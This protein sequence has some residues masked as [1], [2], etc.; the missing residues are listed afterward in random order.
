MNHISVLKDEAISYLNVKPEG[1]YVDCTLGGG[2][3]AEALLTRLKTGKLI[4]FDQDAYAVARAKE[5]LRDHA[6]KLVV[7]EANFTHLKITL[8]RLS[9]D[10]VDGVLYDLGVS[11]FHFDDPSRGFSYN[12]DAPLDMRM[13]TREGVTARE[14]VNTLDQRALKTIF[15]RYAEERF[16]GP[17][18]KAIVTR[19]KT[20]PIETTFELVDVIKSALPMKVL[21]QKGHP[22]KR[23]FQAL[24]IAVNDEL[25]VFEKSLQQALECVRPEGRVVVI[26][27]HSLEDR[28]AK[29]VFRE[30]STIDHPKGLVTMPEGDAPFELLTRK[31]VRPSEE[32]IE[33]NPR[34]SSAKL[35]AIKKR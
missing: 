27:F 12:H 21:S 33:A 6:D 4:A 8:E 26:S 20:H 1:I 18:A 31:V 32:E 23:V 11:S 5:R 19:R 14:L 3:H 24:R 22:A 28:I 7:V 30:A 35:R 16:A 17:I 15:Y 34:A 29:H 10:A 2:G 13:D 9:I 25:N